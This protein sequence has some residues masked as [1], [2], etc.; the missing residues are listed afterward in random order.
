MSLKLKILGLGVFAVLATSALAVMNASATVSGHFAHDADGGHAT[1]KG[2][3]NGIHS[4]HSLSFQRTV[5]DEQTGQKVFSGAAIV[6]NEATYEGT[7][8]SAITNLIQVAPVYKACITTGTEVKVEVTPNGCT[9]TFHSNKNASTHTPTEKATVTVDCP[10]EK[11]IEI[12]HPNCTSTVGAQQL[13]GATYTTVL[14]GGFENLTVRIT[15]KGVTVHFHGGICI[16][17]G[18]KQEFDMNGSVTVKGFNTKGEQVNI[19]AT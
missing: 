4:A 17:L 16:F 9:Y 3:E 8:T 11:A 12:H 6:C 2:F 18:T 19:F 5:T 10:S 14:E 1:I 13:S 7:V 15:V